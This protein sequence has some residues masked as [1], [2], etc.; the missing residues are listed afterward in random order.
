MAKAAA[1]A[2]C[3]EGKEVVAGWTSSRR[4]AGTWSMTGRGRRVRPLATML[5]DTEARARAPTPRS[6]ARR[7]VRSPVAARAAAVPSQS[8]PWLAALV[9]LGS[10]GCAPRRRLSATRLKSLRSR[11][12]IARMGR[13]YGGAGR[14][15]TDAPAAGAV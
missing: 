11:S 2:E 7:A 14:R 4:T 6:A 5:A 1:E 8:T 12:L 13:A 15:V 10:T 9:S 3:P